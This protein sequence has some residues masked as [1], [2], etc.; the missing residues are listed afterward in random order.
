MA[1]TVLY[2]RVGTDEQAK[3]GYSVPDQLRELRRYADAEG[4]EV[5]EEAI[6]DGYSGAS[7]DRPGLHRVMELAESGGVDLILAT[8]RDRLFRSRLWRLTMER[9]LEDFGGCVRNLL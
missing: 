6:D 1:K 8:K 7:P 9:D 4:H 3:R 2:I 5:V